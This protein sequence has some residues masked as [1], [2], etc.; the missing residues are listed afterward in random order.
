MAS[1]YLEIAEIREG[2]SEK[3]GGL[4]IKVT[5]DFNLKE[6]DNVYIDTPQDK[7]AKLVELGFIDESEAD[8]RLEKVPAWKKY[9]LTAKNS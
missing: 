7:I 2:S 3:G 9:I 8:Q 1:K 4:Y 5:K 6:G